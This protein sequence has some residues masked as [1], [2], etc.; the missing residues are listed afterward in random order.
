[1]YS[2]LVLTINQILLIIYL[3]SLHLIKVY[4]NLL[5]SIFSLKIDL[6]LH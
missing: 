2:T 1:M 5:E 4:I 6:D 3:V